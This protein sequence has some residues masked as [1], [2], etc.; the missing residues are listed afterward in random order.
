M[1]YV[2]FQASAVSSAIH[3]VAD[4]A[5][6]FAREAFANY[7]MLDAVHSDNQTVTLSE[8]GRLMR[9]LDIAMVFARLA[10]DME[11]LRDTRLPLL[12]E[13]ALVKFG[14]DGIA[15]KNLCRLL[16]GEEYSLNVLLLKRRW[17]EKL[18]REIDAHIPQAKIHKAACAYDKSDTALKVLKSQ[19][20]D[21]FKRKAAVTLLKKTAFGDDL[22]KR[23]VNIGYEYHFTDIKPLNNLLRD[24]HLP[25]AK[26]YP[27]GVA[28]SAVCFDEKFIF[29]DTHSNC[30]DVYRAIKLGHECAHAVQL[31]EHFGI[32]AHKVEK[33]QKDARANIRQYG[34]LMEAHSIAAEFIIAGE[35]LC[36]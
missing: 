25:K 9:S 36:A 11:Y 4:E 5:R 2:T 6:R 19:V 31:H 14:I 7:R 17:L 26:K 33:T 29:V 23:A 21:P 34:S 22:L 27:E 28:A 3:R 10:A 1:V 12:P 32:G 18:S 13:S 8:V 24:L 15:D 35:L 30:S 20:H 16:S